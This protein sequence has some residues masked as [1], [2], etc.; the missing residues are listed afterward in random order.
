[1]LCPTSTR[2]VSS[3]PTLFETTSQAPESETTEVQES[4]DSTYASSSYSVIS[5]TPTVSADLSFTKKDVSTYYSTAS[6]SESTA[7]TF[8]TTVSADIS[9][10]DRDVSTYYSTASSSESTALNST[11][12]ATE[13]TDCNSNLSSSTL[14]T[15]EWIAIVFAEA[16]FATL[17]IIV[18]ICYFKKNSPRKTAFENEQNGFDPDGTVS[19]RSSTLGLKDFS[20]PCNSAFKPHSSLEVG[21]SIYKDSSLLNV[22]EITNPT[23]NYEEGMLRKVFS[24]SAKSNAMDLVMLTPKME[25]RPLSDKR[26]ALPADSVKMLKTTTCRSNDRIQSAQNQSL[27]DVMEDSIEAEQISATTDFVFCKEYQSERAD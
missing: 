27:K 18:L 22:D 23:Q 17:I 6:S 21:E 16:L 12:I 7:L 9:F 15:N 10:T 8:L 19:K 1:M 24:S 5:S 26:Y 25:K 11:T 4:R 3:A 20:K 13:E 2:G 14:S